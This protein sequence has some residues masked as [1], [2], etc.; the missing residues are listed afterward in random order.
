MKRFSPGPDRA[1][2]EASAGS[3]PDALAAAW[4]NIAIAHLRW[5]VAATDVTGRQLTRVLGVREATWAEAKPLAPGRWTSMKVVLA[6]A[7]VL[8]HQIEVHDRE[9]AW[10]W[11]E[12]KTTKPT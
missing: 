7:D 6:V 11:V 1:A 5:Y 12:W 2:I 8:G 3:D 4:H 10:P 9:R